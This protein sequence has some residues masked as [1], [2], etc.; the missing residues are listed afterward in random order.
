[1]VVKTNLCEYKVINANPDEKDIEDLIAPIEEM[2]Y[3]VCKYYDDP[4][5]ADFAFMTPDILNM[6]DNDI[7]EWEDY[8][9][10]INEKLKISETMHVQQKP[11]NIRKAI[12]ALNNARQTVIDQDN[13]YYAFAKTAHISNRNFPETICAPLEIVEIKTYHPEFDPKICKYRAVS[14]PDTKAVKIGNDLIFANTSTTSPNA[15]T[16]PVDRIPTLI[17]FSKE[18]IDEHCNHVFGDEDPNAMQWFICKTCGKPFSLTRECIDHYKSIGFKPQKNC[19]SCINK[20]KNTSN[21]SSVR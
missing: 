11:S 17:N 1:M 14:S 7:D 12:K 5:V 4:D 21:T 10:K 15:W 18:I 3:R 2:G 19:R 9:D 16:D 20:R 6:I 8:L 13:L